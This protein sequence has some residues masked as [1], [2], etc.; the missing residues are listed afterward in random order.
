MHYVLGNTGKNKDLPVSHLQEKSRYH[1]NV[2]FEDL[3]DPMELSIAPTG[4]V[5]IIQRKGALLV[6]D[7]KTNTT[8]KIGTV[9][10]DASDA[11]HG[12]HGMALSPD[13]TQTRHIFLFL[14]PPNSNGSLMQVC[15][16]TLKAGKLDLPSKKVLLEIPLDVNGSGHLGGSLSFDAEGLLYISTGDNSYANFSSGFSPMDE[17]PGHASNDA[18]RSAG[19]TNDLRGKILRIKPL[20]NGS[21][22]IPESNLFPKDGSQGR[23]EIYVMGCRNPFRIAVDKPTG[24]LYWGEVGPD[25]GKDSTRGSQGYDEINQVRKACN[26]GWPYFIGKNAPYA[27]YN[28]ASGKIGALFNPN[29]PVNNSPNNTGAKKLPPAAPAFIYYPYTPSKEFPEL[30]EGARCALGGPVYHYNPQSKSAIKFPAYYD[31]VLFIGDWS[32][33]WIKAVYMDQDLNYLRTEAFMPNLALNHPIDF[34]FGPDGALYVLEFGDPWGYLQERGKLTR[35]EYN[36][37]NRPPVAVA[38]ASKTTGQAPLK[39]QFSSKGTFDYDEGDKLTYEW[40]LNGKPFGGNAPNPEFTF[41]KPGQFLAVLSVTDKSGATTQSSLK[42][43]VGKTLPALRIASNANQ[44]FYWDNEVFGYQVLV[45]NQ[46]HQPDK[47][48]LRVTLDYLP[49]GKDLP[50]LP[51]QS[52]ETTALKVNKGEQLLRKNDCKSCHMKDEEGY[53]PAFLAVASKYKPTTKTVSELANKVI[54]GGGG[55]WGEHSMN[56]HPQLSKEDA[57]ALVQYILSLSTPELTSLPSEGNL[58]L[59][60]HQGNG[61][62]GKYI[63]TASYAENGA[64]GEEAFTTSRKIILRHPRVESYDFDGYTDVSQ[65]SSG[66]NHFIESKEQGGYL[67]LKNIDLHQISHLTFNYSALENGGLIEVRAGSP[68]GFLIGQ[69][70]FTPTGSW[71][72]WREQNALLKNPGGKPDLYLVFK[73]KALLKPS[74]VRLRWIEFHRKKPVATTSK[75]VTAISS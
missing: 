69:L 48:N 8:E 58:L 11:G 41:H 37:G 5:Y 73:R 43:T 31:D 61:P 28:F 32:R 10:V 6:F 14:T 72:Q 63:L 34:E 38:S 46:Q 3:K 24:T 4:E 75:W 22:S 56:A 47:A 54:N 57:D 62:T 50:G 67:V 30:G 44:S 39:V 55:V 1:A 25:A 29:A 21:Y 26:N 60:K 71:K 15:R 18:Q 45:S 19:N 74:Q 49:E 12:L 36:V 23:P 20:P 59:D 52:K 65:G 70:N 2:L 17:R 33:N 64:N 53:G 35:I 9:P 27:E 16:Y 68:E 42:V 66:N 51:L 7:P 40:T 13:F